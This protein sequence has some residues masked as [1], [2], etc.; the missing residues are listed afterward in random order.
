MGSESA[1]RFG[2]EESEGLEVES[3][4]GVV[5]FEAGMSMWI[6]FSG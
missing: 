1:G 5:V 4:V 3:R 6:G 2:D